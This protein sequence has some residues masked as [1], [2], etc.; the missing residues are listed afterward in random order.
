M[1]K[2]M[3][4][5]A[6]FDR[7]RGELLALQERICGVLEA[8]DAGAQ[9][10]RDEMPRP[11]GG[12]S[13]P[14]VLSDGQVIERAAVNFTHTIGSRMPAAATERRPDL[15]GRNYHA[16]SISLIVHP[17][18]PYVPTTHA[19]FRFLI[20]EGSEAG[21]QDPAAESIWWFG[22]GYDLTPYYGFVE[23]AVH[24]HRTARDACAPHGSDLYETLKKDCD[25]YFYLPHREEA[26]GIGGLFFDDLSDGGFERCHAL[27]YAIADSF[28]DAYKP[29][30]ARR[31]NTP[32]SD[33]QRDFQQVRR[34]RYVEFNLLYDRGTRFGLQAG[35]RTESVLASLPPTVQW[36][37]DFK[38][39][40][41]SPEAALCKDFLT[42]RDWLSSDLETAGHSDV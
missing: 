19:N 7:V 37:Y 23:D 13:R 29:I 20:T 26:R 2:L 28:L 40:R 25:A 42:P 38:P 12:L 15:V 41:G 3:G 39:E 6:D 21:K 30:L 11:G 16:V 27:W 14:W 4:S 35:A 33:R 36:R 8:E 34:G 31:K 22:G 18:N 10:V 32:Y 5:A 9:F 1:S 17:R 24:W